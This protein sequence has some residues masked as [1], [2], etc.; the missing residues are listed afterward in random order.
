MAALEASVG[1]DHPDMAICLNNVG[2]VLQVIPVIS[3]L[4]PPTP[5]ISAGP[6]NFILVANL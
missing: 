5:K 4:R 2:M 1:A 6:A 3:Q